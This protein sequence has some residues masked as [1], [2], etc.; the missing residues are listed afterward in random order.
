MTLDNSTFDSN[1]AY[2]FG[3]TMY[4]EYNNNVVIKNSTFL[5][6]YVEQQE[7]G[8]LYFYNGNN[9][10]IYSTLFQNNFGIIFIKD[11]YL[12]ILINIIYKR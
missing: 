11:I 5:N 8:A 3:G 12:Y 7:A 4:T 2:S 10:E 6:N 1:F 9:V